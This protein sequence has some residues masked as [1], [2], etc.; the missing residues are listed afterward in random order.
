[1]LQWYIAIIREATEARKPQLSLAEQAVEGEVRK[2][3]KVCVPNPI[4]LR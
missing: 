3:R 2:G 1:M 4:S